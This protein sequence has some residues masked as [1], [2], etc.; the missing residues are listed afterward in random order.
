MSK[1]LQAARKLLKE[2]AISNKAIKPTQLVTISNQLGK[3]LM[4][5]LNLI[6][7]LKT[8]GQ[9]YSAFPQTAKVLTGEYQ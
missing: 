3:S 9:G 8:S 6:S 2:S 1:D 7:F 4:E 5:T